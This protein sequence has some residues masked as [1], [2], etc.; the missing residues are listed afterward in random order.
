MIGSKLTRRLTLTLLAALCCLLPARAAEVES[1]CGQRCALHQADFVQPGSTFG[2][3]YL[4]EVPEES[5]GRL[6]YGSRVLRCGDVLPQSAL[7]QLCFYPAGEQDAV[8][9]VRYFTIRDSQLC[10]EAEL[11]IRIK[12]GE[13]QPPEAKDSTLQTYKNLQRQGQLD[14]SD[15]EGDALTF[16]ITAQPKRGTVELQEDGSFVYTPKEN[17]VGKDSFR[18]TATDAAGNCSGE[19]TVSIE[20]LKPVDKAAYADMQ[21]DTDE[22]EALWLRSTGLYSGQEIS[23]QLCFAP[24][25][26]LTRGEF[27]AMAMGMA[28]IEPEQGELEVKLADYDETP[29]WLKP[30]LVSALRCGIVRGTPSEDGL[31]FCGSDPVT[32]AQA[33]VML[34]NILHLQQPEDSTVF[35]SEHSVPAWA[36]QS[37]QALSQAGLTL[38]GDCAAPLTHRQAACLLYEAST[39]LPD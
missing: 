1:V 10:D 14:V 39:L 22:F 36:M 30:Y 25:Q 31:R 21:G 6:Q 15:P 38:S 8:A 26:T 9:C 37:V 16:A 35:A 4:A 23:G 3:V 13:N 34:Q 18:Y 2:G 33:A 19:A 24:E 32:G 7:D 17:K 12:S 29:E 28:G 27:L 11:T 5:M 20:I